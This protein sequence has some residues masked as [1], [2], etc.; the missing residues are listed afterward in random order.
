MTK[1]ESS[2]TSSVSDAY[3]TAS[4]A[5]ERYWYAAQGT[6]VRDLRKMTDKNKPSA[7]E[8]EIHPLHRRALCFPAQP[9]GYALGISPRRGVALSEA[10]RMRTETKG[11]TAWEGTFMFT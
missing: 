5:I 7:L 1:A 3:M 4:K 6:G 10:E 2:I 8:S 9:D 11:G